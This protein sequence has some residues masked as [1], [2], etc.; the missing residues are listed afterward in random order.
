M[1]VAV[2]VL[3][4]SWFWGYWVWPEG[5]VLFF[6]TVQNRSHEWGVRVYMQFCIALFCLMVVVFQ[7]T[8]AAVSMVFCIG[9]AAH[10][11]WHGC[12]GPRRCGNEQVCAR[13][14][15]AVCR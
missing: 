6:N 2:S 10:A 15:G 12:V 8:D 14:S 11:T 5:V 1:S 9:S 7:Y 3:I 13:V 4:D